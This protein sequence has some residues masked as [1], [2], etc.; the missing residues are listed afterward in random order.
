VKFREF[1]IEGTLIFAA[2]A[3]ETLSIG[4]NA[5]FGRRLIPTITDLLGPLTHEKKFKIITW[6]FLGYWWDH[7]YKRGCSEGK[8][9]HSL[10]ASASVTAGGS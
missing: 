1:P 5:V 10:S 9:V 6:V 4:L 2:V 8:C 3:Y 7:F